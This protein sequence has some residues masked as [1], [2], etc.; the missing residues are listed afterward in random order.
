MG[1][2]KKQKKRVEQTCQERL[3]NPIVGLLRLSELYTQR[4]RSAAGTISAMFKVGK[5]KKF[6]ATENNAPHPWA[7]QET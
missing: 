6:V 4:C 3:R 7:V 5:E 2:I 1:P